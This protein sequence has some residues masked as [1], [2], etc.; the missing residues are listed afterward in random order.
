MLPLTAQSV[1]TTP[2]DAGAGEQRTPPTLPPAPDR[3][4]SVDGDR[5][6]AHAALLVFTVLL[7]LWAWSAVRSVTSDAESPVLQPGVSRIPHGPVRP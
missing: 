7:A 5:D 6:L 4:L 2:H 1:T 3:F